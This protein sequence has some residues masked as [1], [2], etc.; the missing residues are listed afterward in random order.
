VK[1]GLFI[2][3]EGGDGSGKSTHAALLAGHLKARG[4]PTLHTREPGGTPLA[5]GVRR[6]L[7]NPRHR[8]APLTELFLYE[9]ARAQHVAETIRPALKK[10]IWVVCERYT[11]ATLAYQGWGRGLD[12]RVLRLLNR[13]A[14]GGLVPDLTFL[15][16]A[17]VGRA[18]A[19]ARGRRGG[20]RLERE[21]LGFH[22]RVDK[23]YRTLA[24]RDPRRWRVIPRRGS[25]TVVQGRLRAEVEEFL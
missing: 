25:I 21:P 14:T 10:G 11:D 2:T 19:L 5:E 7:L 12:L 15:L 3:F 9:A 4:I 16:A 8:P 1:R 23:G 24:R 13:T 20:D 17:P 18:V 6:I 22:R